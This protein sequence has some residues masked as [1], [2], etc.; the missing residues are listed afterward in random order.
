MKKIVA[1]TAFICIS[2]LLYCTEPIMPYPKVP[3]HQGSFV[4][5]GFAVLLIFVLSMVLALLS[6]VVHSIDSSIKNLSCDCTKKREENME[7]INNEVSFVSTTISNL[8]SVIL[9]LAEEFGIN[10][11]PM[12]RA[13][14]LFDIIMRGH[15]QTK[16]VK[17]AELIRGSNGNDK[18]D[19]LINLS[20]S[21]R[22]ITE[23]EKN[24]LNHIVIKET[25]VRLG[26]YL[27]CILSTEGWERFII[28]SVEPI[29]SVHFHNRD[30]YSIITS[31]YNCL[32]KDV[33]KIKQT[34]KGD[35]N[36]EI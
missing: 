27:N 30:T 14:T 21:Y 32:W 28:H 13:I 22:T 26:S 5:W 10:G 6:F 11:W 17:M 18:D 31:T 3:D 23:E 8:N 16:A 2:I 29:L 12:E 33:V 34:I 15:C 1:L 36:E 20:H 9:D 35:M 4:N 7:F 24:I 19:L 25:G